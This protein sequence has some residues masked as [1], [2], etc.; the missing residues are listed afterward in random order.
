MQRVA[1]RDVDLA[2]FKTS[3]GA[4]GFADGTAAVKR[5]AIV[6]MAWE[7]SQQLLTGTV[8]DGGGE[9]QDGF[10]LV[11]RLQRVP[12]AVSPR[13][14]QLRRGHRL[15]ARGRPGARR[16]RRDPDARDHAGGRHRPPVHVAVGAVPRLAARQPAGERRPGGRRDSRHR[17]AGGGA[18]AGA[19]LDR[20]QPLPQLLDPRQ[21]A[22]AGRRRHPQAQAPGAAGAAGPASAAGW[23]ATCR[24]PGSTTCCSATSSRPRT[25]ACCTSYSRST[26]P[27]P[28]SRATTPTTPTAGTAAT[29][30][31]W[32]SP[33]ASPTSC[34]RYSS[35]R[36]RSGCRSSTGASRAPCRRR[37][38]PSSP[39]TSPATRPRC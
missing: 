20:Q 22:A 24:G 37:A 27:A 30:S 10:R 33:A 32:T 26:G 17:A 36:T 25:C 13:V 34:G 3:V 2:S 11:P 35:R 4:D 7:A 1:L 12:I 38:R 31:T 6:Q 9:I 23:R 29:R 39:W 19:E 5:G 21:A 14:L 28:P 8:K 18:L 15:R 16:H